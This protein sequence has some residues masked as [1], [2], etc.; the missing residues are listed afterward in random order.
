MKIV[1]LSAKKKHKNTKQTQ[2]LNEIIIHFF[3]C[4]VRMTLHLGRASKN[5]IH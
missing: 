1:R 2:K 3:C 5:C 4:Y